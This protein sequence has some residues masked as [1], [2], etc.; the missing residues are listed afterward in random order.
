MDA[1]MPEAVHI[2]GVLCQTESPPILSCLTRL[3]QNWALP[4]SPHAKHA[5]E[6]RL[7][8]GPP[9]W[10]TPEPLPKD[11]GRVRG[12]L[13]DGLPTYAVGPLCGQLRSDRRA[14]LWG[15]VEP[16]LVQLSDLIA[17]LLYEVLA[18]QGFLA[19]HAAS[20]LTERAGCL[21]LGPSGAGK[22]TL[23][24]LAA[25]GG[26]PYGG[27]D[28]CLLEQSDGAWRMHGTGPS[29][30]IDSRLRLPDGFVP[31][32][33]Q[34]EDKLT[35]VPGGHDGGYRGSFAIGLIVHLQGN[36]PGQTAWRPM[37][38]EESLKALLSQAFIPL[39]PVWAQGALDS[40]LALNQLPTVE[41]APGLDLLG[42]PSAA[43]QSLEAICREHCRAL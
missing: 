30:H 35:L 43:L 6:F 12:W 13:Q 40:L 32:D 2:G 21:V 39:R 3:R 1:D 5:L 7:L 29:V 31:A 36:H 10:E 34:R 9:P 4:P 42:G 41:L 20:L 18:E 27:D 15:P 17:A 25:A 23:T 37:G 11:Q 19:L 16:G 26:A 8:A 24:Y 28:L 33:Q 14:L 38:R 22:S